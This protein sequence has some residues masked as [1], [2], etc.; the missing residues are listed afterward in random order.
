MLLP[1]VV[2]FVAGLCD[3][4]GVFIRAICRMA[5]EQLRIKIL[6]SGNTNRVQI[7]NGDIS[8]LIKI[9]VLATQTDHYI[10]RG[11][12]LAKSEGNAWLKAFRALKSIYKPAIE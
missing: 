2:L 7:S 1:F 11:V 6:N 3:L 5:R 4:V 9:D 8:T 10:Y 12:P